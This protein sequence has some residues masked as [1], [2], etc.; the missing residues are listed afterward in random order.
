LYF[1]VSAGI[2]TH[3]GACSQ[4]RLIAGLNSDLSSSVPA[5]TSVLPVP[6]FSMNIG[7]PHLVQKRRCIGSPLWPPGIVNVVIV[8][9]IVT[10]SAGNA[11]PD[12]KAVPVCF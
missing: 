8:P 3:D 1:W 2:T 5:M 12:T 11:M 9:V 10:P 6:S 7:E 4:N